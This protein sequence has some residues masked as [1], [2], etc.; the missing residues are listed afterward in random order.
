MV[1]N[2]E[3]VWSIVRHPNYLGDALTHF[4]FPVLPWSTGLLRPLAPAMRP[5]RPRLLFS[6]S[7][8]P[9]T[10]NPWPN[11]I[12]S[13]RYNAHFTIQRDSPLSVAMTVGIFKSTILPSYGFHTGLSLIDYGVSHYADRA[14][15]KDWLWPTSPVANAWW[16]TLRLG[17]RV[18]Y[19]GLSLPAAWA[20]LT[21]CE[22]LLLTGVT[23]WGIRPFYRIA[24]RSLRCGTDDGRMQI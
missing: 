23:T 16:S 13:L 24:S 4:P 17:T 15:G 20:Q 10:Y 7:P 2:C 3:G 11:R 14:D 9:T 6:L 22:K 21:Y 1:L 18:V 19:D 12:V 8:A 5:Q